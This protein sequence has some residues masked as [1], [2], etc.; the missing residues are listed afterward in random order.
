MTD[1]SAD[2]LPITDVLLLDKIDYR[3]ET[4]NNESVMLE[5]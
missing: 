3:T 5:F 2:T 1:I 4:Y